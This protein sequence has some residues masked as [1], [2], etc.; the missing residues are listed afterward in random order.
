[1]HVLTIFGLPLPYA[2][3]CDDYLP[4]SRNKP[5]APFILGATGD[6]L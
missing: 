1:V 2:A 3:H 4:G 6:T 5:I